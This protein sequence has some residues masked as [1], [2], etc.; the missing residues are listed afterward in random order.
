MSARADRHQSGAETGGNLA[1]TGAAGTDP[2]RRDDHHALATDT[3][4]EMP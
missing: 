1:I 2:G 4:L 3:G